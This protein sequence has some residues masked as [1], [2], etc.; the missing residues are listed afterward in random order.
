MILYLKKKKQDA[1]KLKKERGTL[2]EE[3][4]KVM[5]RLAATNDEDA[6]QYNESVVP[7]LNKLIVPYQNYKYRNPEYI[8]MNFVTSQN[9]KEVLKNKFQ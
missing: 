2:S 3:G 9:I 6:D 1:D 5:N 8:D 4:I 7:E